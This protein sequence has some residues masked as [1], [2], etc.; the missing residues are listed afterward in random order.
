MPNQADSGSARATERPEASSGDANEAGS[1]QGCYDGAQ[2]GNDGGGSSL[3]KSLGVM[4][5]GRHADDR[6]RDKPG[7]SQA[8]FCDRLDA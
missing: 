8:D 7:G 1:A 4:A 6:V 3:L 2:A 5:A